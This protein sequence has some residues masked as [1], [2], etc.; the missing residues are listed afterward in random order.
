MPTTLAPHIAPDAPLLAQVSAL[1]DCVSAADF[2]RLARLC[3]DDF[4]IVDLD[5]EGKNVLVRTRAEWEGWFQ[6]LFTTLPALGA[7]TYTHITRYDVLPT[8]EMALCVVEFTQ[9]LQLGAER[10]PFDCV[11]T[12]VWQRPK[13]ADRP[14]EGGWVEARWHVSLLERRAP[15]PVA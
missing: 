8:A 4:G 10:H 13:H 9:Y 7:H 12:I 14:G 15:E 5:P 3:D 11:V 1:F 2:D 6:R